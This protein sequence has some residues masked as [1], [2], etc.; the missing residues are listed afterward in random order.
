MATSVARLTNYDARPHVRDAS[1]ISL[2]T[3]PLNMPSF[4][5]KL[6]L[7]QQKKD[8]IVCECVKYKKSAPQAKLP[9]GGVKEELC[10]GHS[11]VSV[12]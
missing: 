3:A 4:S 1:W 11:A 8:W 10:C 12:H 7:K 2:T 6:F 5:I 9:W